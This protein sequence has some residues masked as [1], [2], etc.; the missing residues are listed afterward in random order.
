MSKPLTQLECRDVRVL[1]EYYRRALF[2]ALADL[3]D[4]NRALVI[5]HLQ[6]E[7]GIKFIEGQYPSIQEIQNALELTIGSSSRIFIDRFRRELEK[8]A[9]PAK[10]L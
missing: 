4:Q 1:K 6:K 9:I 10:L 3:G 2:D 5:Y 7:H 8:F